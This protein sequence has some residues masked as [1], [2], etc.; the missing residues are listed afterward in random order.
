[1]HGRRTMLSLAAALVALAAA[2]PVL[3]ATPNP[4]A[5]LECTFCHSDTP[6]FGVDTRDTVNFWRAEGD[7]PHLCEG[8]HG[9]EANFHPLG[10][11]P[12]P[13]R[14]DT[15]APRRLPLGTSEAVRGQ[16]VC[17]TCHFVH[18]AD[19]D[20]SLLRGFPGSDDPGLFTAWQDLCRECHGAGLEKR[21]PHA[22]D[23]RSCA[24]CHSNRPQAG[25]PVTVTPSG[26]RLCEFCHG[27]KQEKHYAGVNPFKEPQDCTGCHDPHSGKDRP[28]RLR[29]GYIDPIRDAVTLNPHLKRT[30]CFACHADGKPSPL[31]AAAT[32]AVCQR[33]HG[34]GKIPGMSHP[35]NKVPAGYAIPQGWP[36]VD[37]AMTCV[38]CHVPGHAPGVIAGRPDEPA[39]PY[40]LRGAVG[41]ERTAVCFRC[42][43]RNQWTGRSPHREVAQ[44]QTGC[45]QCHAVN[46]EEGDPESFV[47]DINIV[48]LACHDNREHPG[49]T[50]HTVTLTAAMPEVPGSL[51]LGTGR[52]ITC[53]TCHDP[54]LDSPAGHRLRG[55]SEPTAFCLRCHKL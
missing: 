50:R 54:H 42:H 32:V 26:R 5:D 12:D 3:A 46:P 51:P 7:E 30:F 25:K 1:M 24:F 13:K 6:R 45:T 10:V 34:S 19:A 35:M 48:C 53:A 37:G 31:Q 23:E 22:G 18:A 36:L 15:R 33:C 20:H 28:A 27:F 14:M 2:A 21:S 43:A 17:I 8:C 52:R 29:A 40:L 38:T 39:A 9:P 11:A 49:E 41:G 47:A 55:A 4:H 16:V 44:K